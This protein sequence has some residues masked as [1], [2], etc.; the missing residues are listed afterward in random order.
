[1]T[2]IL[3]LN[4]VTLM[5][6]IYF[7]APLISLFLIVYAWPKRKLPIVQAFIGLMMSAAI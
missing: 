5:R 6:Y 4:V 7:I 1:M 3:G 2:M